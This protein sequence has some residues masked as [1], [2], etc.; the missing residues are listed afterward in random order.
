VTDVQLSATI[1][2]VLEYLQH[3]AGT[4]IAADDLY[5]MVDC[6]LRDAHIA[7]DTLTQLR[8]IER[9][10]QVNGTVTYVA[11]RYLEAARPGT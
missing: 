8:R 10:Q 7:L 5:T 3:N 1:Q 11:N 2:R 4:P 9:L 6:T